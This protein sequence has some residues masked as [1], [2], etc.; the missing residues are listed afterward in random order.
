MEQNRHRPPPLGWR[1]CRLSLLLT[2][3][4]LSACG[5]GGGGAT[6][7]PTY[8][9]GGTVSGL[10]TGMEVI[11]QN[12]GSDPLTVPANGAFTFSARLAAGGSYSVTVGT[13]PVVQICSVSNGSGS[14]LTA[15]V[16]NVTV[17]C[18]TNTYTIGG[19][20]SGL[21]SG[22]EVT[23][24]DN[25]TDPLTL[26][27][28]GTFSFST[29]LVYGATYS[30][31]VSSQPT[32]QFCDVGYGD[33][34]LVVSGA[35]TS[36]RVIC[37]NLHVLYSFRG[38]SDGAAPQVGPIMDA[39]GN[40]YGTTL[41]GGTGGA[42]TVFKL[43]AGSGGAYVESV[44]YN[45]QGT[46]SG[47]GAGP[48]SKLIVDSAGNLY[49]TTSG[50]GDSGGGT[51]FRLAP[52][53]SGGYTESIL[54][55]FSGGQTDG[56]APVGGVIMDAVGNLFGV[57][58]SG[59]SGEEGVVYKLTPATAGGY[60]ESILYSFSSGTGNWGYAAGDLFIDNA[61]N[62]YGTTTGGGEFLSGFVFKLVPNATGGY[63]GSTVYAFPV[64]PNWE[65]SGQD[66]LM[67]DGAG[68]LYGTRENA[69]WVFKLSPGG[70]AGYDETLLNRF[71]NDF[72]GQPVG[73]VVSDS[74]GN[75]YGVTSGNYDV[76]GNILY[77][78]VYELSPSSS[79]VGYTESSLYQF[80]GTYGSGPNGG[81]VIDSAGNL[82]G[83]TAG[84]GAGACMNADGAVGGCGTVF[85][86]RR[87]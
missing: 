8:T 11:L 2:A 85:E 69:S 52:N 56:L 12:N 40:F 46:N 61:S 54:Y 59:G 49:S 41:N 58:R 24:L 47:D 16:T 22:Q 39:A 76:S 33:E 34:S 31:T 10:A 7:G 15:D 20:I 9:V 17:T 79:S 25:G 36:V 55:S 80:T 83:T 21:A 44:L 57:T 4:A 45:F 32:Q 67:M 73:G 87:H 1:P 60:A 78:I 64:S 26:A 63:D 14:N 74:E 62:L 86:L 23:L 6:P 75:L 19:S 5:G 72:E 70:S 50:G 37:A 82:Y 3:L 66:D 13:Q 51:V 65:V 68:N 43:S 42:G 27:A 81:L 48:D 29:P 35:V 18:V 38:G 84:G 77:G 71:T 30:V 28:N 53:G